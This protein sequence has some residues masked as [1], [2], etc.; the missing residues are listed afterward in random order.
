MRAEAPFVKLNGKS[1]II[2]RPLSGD[3]RIPKCNA[4]VIKENKLI[5]IKT[6]Y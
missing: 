2:I 1:R 6:L 3:V 4:V 5:P